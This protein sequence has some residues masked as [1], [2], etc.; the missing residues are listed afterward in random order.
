FFRLSKMESLFYCSILGNKKSRKR[1]FCFKVRM[2]GIEPPRLAAP[3]PKSGVSTSSTTSAEKDCKYTP[4]YFFTNFILSIF[5]FSQF[6]VL[7]P[8]SNQL[9]KL[10][11]ES[12][13]YL[14]NSHLQADFAK[15]KSLLQHRNSIRRIF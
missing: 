9:W 15:K 7:L 8:K 10:A 6:P 14:K 13:K 3:D 4:K 12:R 5:C 11:A 1:T 2:K